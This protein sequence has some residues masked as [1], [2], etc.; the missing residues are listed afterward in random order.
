MK[1][2]NK[3]IT[4]LLT[5]N[6]DLGT[7]NIVLPGKRPVVFIKR[8]LQEKNYSGMLPNFFTVE[9]LIKEIQKL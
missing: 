5:Q 3:I 7:F 9:D 1:F 2:L 4:E 6:K 8:I